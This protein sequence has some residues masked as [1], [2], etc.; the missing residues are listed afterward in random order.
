[1]VSGFVASGMGIGT[2]LVPMAVDRL[3]HAEGWRMAFVALALLNL[4]GGGAVALLIK[5]SSQPPT[6]TERPVLVGPL[7]AGMKTRQF[8]FIFGVGLFASLGYQLPFA[9][10]VAF[11]EQKGILDSTSV[12]LLGLIGVGS[13]AGRLLG[14]VGDWMGSRRALAGFLFATAAALAYW[15]WAQTTL[16]IGIFTLLFGVC[17]GGMVALTAPFVSEH[18]PASQAGKLSSFL[19]LCLSSVGIGAFIGPPTAS[20]IHDVCNSYTV[21][22]CVGVLSMSVSAILVLLLP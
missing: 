1:M 8:R 7:L 11:A 6:A 22:I 17:Y 19:G 10:I 5:R 15:P 12:T 13:I 14:W 21:P 4:L 9:H 2:L 16:E 18:L 20:F 3:I